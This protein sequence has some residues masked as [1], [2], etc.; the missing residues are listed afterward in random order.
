[1][2]SPQIHSG[3]QSYSRTGLQLQGNSCTF[4]FPQPTNKA[5][6]LQTPDFSQFSTSFFL[7][8]KS[9]LSSFSLLLSRSQAPSPTNLPLLLL[10]TRY[11]FTPFSIALAFLLPAYQRFLLPHSSLSCTLTFLPPLIQFPSIL[12]P[13]LCGSLA[14]WAVCVCWLPG[15]WHRDASNS[16]SSSL[17]L[18]EPCP[19]ALAGV[20]HPGRLTLCVCFTV[21]GAPWFVV[22]TQCMGVNVAVWIGNAC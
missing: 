4:P 1:M 10:K 12:S 20:Q 11:I 18:L 6:V 13:P 8:F 15:V 14:E 22:S 2:G 21:C 9:F 7:L 3:V 16:Q 17:H 5:A 19:L